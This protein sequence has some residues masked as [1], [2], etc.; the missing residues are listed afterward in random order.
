MTSLVGDTVTSPEVPRP[1]A[2]TTSDGVDDSI[3]GDMEPT[4]A[5]N[6][7]NAYIFTQTHIG[8]PINKVN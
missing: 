6:G 5:S 7:F 8:K 3:A 2:V 1:S 4:S